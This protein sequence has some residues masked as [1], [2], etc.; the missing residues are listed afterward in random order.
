[1]EGNGC[2]WRILTP[3]DKDHK[4]K[5]QFP[6]LLSR[7]QTSPFGSSVLPL[8]GEVNFMVNEDSEKEEFWQV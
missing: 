8:F 4:K 5:S 6:L 1:M 2:D 3:K 7:T